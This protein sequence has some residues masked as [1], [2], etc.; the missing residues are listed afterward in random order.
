M[1][2]MLFLKSKSFD[3]LVECG[4]CGVILRCNKTFG[5]H[6][7]HFALVVLWVISVAECANAL[8]RCPSSVFIS[9]VCG[10]VG[11]LFI[12]EHNQQCKIS[13]E[14]LQNKIIPRYLIQIWW[15]W[16][17]SSAS[18]A[19]WASL[20]VIGK[21]FL[22]RWHWPRNHS[23]PERWKKNSAVWLVKGCFFYC[24]CFPCGRFCCFPCSFLRWH[25]LHFL[26][27]LF[28]NQ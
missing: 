14:F 5:G 16:D 18:V 13:L 1:L 4:Q 10:W 25:C 12:Q 26:F 23:D 17:P 15:P 21:L 7:F 20:L 6:I 2:Q 22:L 27:G 28:S 19:F 3:E 9:G 24:R 11:G 8:P